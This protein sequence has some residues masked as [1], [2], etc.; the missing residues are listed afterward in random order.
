MKR[1]IRVQEGQERYSP[2]PSAWRKWILNGAL[3][4]AVVRAGRIVM[5]DTAVLDE[6]LARTGQLLIEGRTKGLASAK[7]KAG[8]KTP[9]S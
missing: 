1:F 2:K 6:R 7:S 8:A 3:G 9:R 5:L 4:D